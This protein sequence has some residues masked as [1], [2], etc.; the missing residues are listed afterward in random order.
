MA[1]GAITAKAAMTALRVFL[2]K[3]LTQVMKIAAREGVKQGAKELV[4]E[5][6]QELAEWGIE[7]SVKAY[8][9]GLQSKAKDIQNQVSEAFDDGTLG[10]GYVYLLGQTITCSFPSLAPHQQ[11]RIMQETINQC[12][13]RV[14][15]KW[16]KRVGSSY[17]N[18]VVQQVGRLTLV[19]GDTWAFPPS[20][21]NSDVR[22][23][24]RKQSI[25]AAKFRA[26]NQKR[27]LNKQE[28][29]FADDPLAW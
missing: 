4:K 9:N 23:I 6:L 12:H 19:S 15:N 3:M 2:K 20:I 24:E 25:M 11:L 28:T 16:H 26:E 17:L 13:L 21:W 18:R 7:T 22:I 5:G 8:I 10:M 29:S 27:K 14:Y 1:V